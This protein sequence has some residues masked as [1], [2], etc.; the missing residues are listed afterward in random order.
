[1]SIVT[2]T[3]RTTNM[4]IGRANRRANRTHTGINTR[5]CAT[6]ILTILTFTIA[7]DTPTGRIAIT[8]I[9]ST[10]QAAIIYRDRFGAL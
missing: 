6:S 10:K 5:R 1:M 8:P 9:H 2:F 3:T 7:M 4:S